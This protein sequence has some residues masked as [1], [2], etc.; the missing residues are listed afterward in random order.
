MSNSENDLETDEQNEKQRLNK[1][2]AI[3]AVVMFGLSFVW[4]ILPLIFRGSS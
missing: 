1:T 3:I 4:H 2:L